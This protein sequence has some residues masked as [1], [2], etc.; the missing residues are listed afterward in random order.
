MSEEPAEK[1]SPHS[2]HREEQADRLRMQQVT[3]AM[4]SVRELPGRPG[5]PDPP[6]V[7]S[8]DAQQQQEGESQIKQRGA[9]G[10]KEERG[11]RRSVKQAGGEGA[12]GKNDNT[13]SQHS[14]NH[15]AIIREGDTRDREKDKGE[16]ST[17][18]R[19]R[20]WWNQKVSAPRVSV[21]TL[22]FFQVVEKSGQGNDYWWSKVKGKAV[23]S[24]Y[25]YLVD[26]L[27]TLFVFLGLLLHLLSLLYLIDELEEVPQVQ[28]YRL[29]LEQNSA[30]PTHVNNINL[31]RDIHPKKN[32]VRVTGNFSFMLQG[33]SVSCSCS[34]FITCDLLS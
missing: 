19:W 21:L 14:G 30:V 11:K 8:A 3:A 23:V 17:M 2:A 31:F 26:R 22:M 20:F 13:S 9:E 10:R 33:H 27:F 32:A 4:W 7:L 1:V 6:P 18:G 28:Y 29:S 12:G 15:S 24:S 34:T 25:E 16:I 5:P